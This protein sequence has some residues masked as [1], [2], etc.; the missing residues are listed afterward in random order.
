MPLVLLEQSE[1]F[2][3]YCRE[4]A[5]QISRQ[6]TTRRY[7]VNYSV[8]LSPTRRSPVKYSVEL[9]TR[10]YLGNYRGVSDVAAAAAAFHSVVVEGVPVVPVV[11]ES[12]LCYCTA[13]PFWFWQGLVI[14]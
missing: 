14:D 6:F 3:G 2:P 12:R 11:P 4:Y 1:T 5:I 8:E 9:S 13:F 10:R 7:P